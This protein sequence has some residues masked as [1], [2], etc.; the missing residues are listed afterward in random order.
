MMVA[1]IRFPCALFE[2]VVSQLRPRRHGWLFFIITYF[3]PCCGTGAIKAILRCNAAT[4]ALDGL[5]G[6]QGSDGHSRNS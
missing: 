3:A 5:V 1:P 2:S 6:H 4:G